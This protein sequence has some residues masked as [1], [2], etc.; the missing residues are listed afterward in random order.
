MGQT[1]LHPFILHMQNVRVV[2]PNLVYAVGLPLD[3]CNEELL[4]EQEYFGQFGKVFK[5]RRSCRAGDVQGCSL[6]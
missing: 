4:R 1:F 5:V 2:Q 6:D 3:I